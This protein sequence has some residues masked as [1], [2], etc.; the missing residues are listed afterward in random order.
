MGRTFSLATA[1]PAVATLVFAPL[2][3]QADNS[4]VISFPLTA[5]HDNGPLVE[6][7]L[8][9]RQQQEGVTS[10]I[11]GALYTIDVTLGTPGQNVPVKFDTGSHLLWANP[12]CP[13]SS[14]QAACQALPRFTYSTTLVDT[15][16]MGTFTYEDGA[17]V[18]FVFVSDYVGI[19]SARISQQIFGAAYSSTKTPTAILGAGPDPSNWDGSFPLPIQKLFDQNHI[20]SRTFSVNLKGT[21]ICSH[22]SVAGYCG[23]PP[24]N[25]HLFATLRF[26]HLRWSRHQKV[27]GYSRRGCRD[28]RRRIPRWRA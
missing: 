22:Q 13:M 18:G 14:N 10:R 7:G 11:S 15:G 1:L 9:K 6:R 16:S 20:Q 2:A 8:S 4:G 17:S 23:L 19:G 25:N 24:A 27:Q 3:V 21:S 26:N 12:N 28:P 5:H